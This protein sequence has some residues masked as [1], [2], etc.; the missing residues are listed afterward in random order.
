[1]NLIFVDYTFFFF[2][3]LPFFLFFNLSFL[4]FF[5]ELSVSSLAA[6]SSLQTDFSSFLSVAV[7]GLISI[8]F[9]STLI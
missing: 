7:L 2:S 1:M 5:L 8:S 9:F 4:S 6:P 3:F